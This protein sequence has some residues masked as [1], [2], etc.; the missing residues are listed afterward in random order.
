[1]KKEPKK[2]KK[3]RQIEGSQPLLQAEVEQL[4]KYLLLLGKSDESTR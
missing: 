4:R 2:P 1:M 3:Q